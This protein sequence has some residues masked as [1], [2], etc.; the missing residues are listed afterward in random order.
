MRNVT[1]TV[2]TVGPRPRNNPTLMFHQRDLSVPMNFHPCSGVIILR[3]SNHTVSFWDGLHWQHLNRAGWATTFD[4]PFPD[5]LPAGHWGVISPLK[6]RRASHWVQIAVS[7]E[8]LEWALSV[9][10]SVADQTNMK[11]TRELVST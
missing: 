2:A 8:E 1:T 7:I 6:K 5:I 3:D 11:V 4:A 10:E 9:P